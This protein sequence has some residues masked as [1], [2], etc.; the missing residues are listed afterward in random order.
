[1]PGERPEWQTESRYPL[2]DRAI[3]EGKYLY[4]VRFGVDTCY[5]MLDIDI[6]SI[7]HPKRDPQILS[8]ILALLEKIGIVEAIV[9]QSSRSEGINIY[10]PLDQLIKSWLIALVVQTL[11]EQ[12]GFKFKFGELEIFPN[13]RSST[14]PIPTSLYRGHRL[15]LQNGSF[16]LNQDWQPI[17]TSQSTFV[18]QWKFAQRRNQLDLAECERIAFRA[19]HRHPALKGRAQK[20]YEDLQTEVQPGWTGEGQTNHLLGRIAMLLYIFGSIDNSML[21]TEEG[22]A[23]EIVATARSLPG[24]EEFCQHRHEI[25]KRARDWA[26]DIIADPHYYPYKQRSFKTKPPS[27]N[28]SEATWNERQRATTRSRIENGRTKL[29]RQN[30]YP[31]TVMGR[32]L[33]FETLGITRGTL[34]KHKDLWHPAYTSQTQTQDAITAPEISR[35]LESPQEKEFAPVLSSSFSSEASESPQEKEFAPLAP[36]K[37]SSFFPSLEVLDLAGVC[38]LFGYLSSL[39]PFSSTQ[40]SE[41]FRERPLQQLEKLDRNDKLDRTIQS[42]QSP[43]EEYNLDCPGRVE[44]RSF[45]DSNANDDSLTLVFIQFVKQQKF[46]DQCPRNIKS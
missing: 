3:E 32:I 18:A 33:A 43:I 41:S 12:A 28:P 7:Y 22:L 26:R 21:L 24:Y 11:L 1:M 13:P 37:L 40:S 9:V 44:D 4:G 29:I 2:S 45:C 39:I 19:R 25:E 10:I 15:P 27:K 5:V 46:K 8:Q 30:N 23:S 20:F 42:E 35:L 38:F 17:S 31:P 14:G 34:Y 16:L 36:N 6:H